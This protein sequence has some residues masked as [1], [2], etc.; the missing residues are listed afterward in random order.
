LHLALDDEDEL[1]AVVAVPRMR[2]GARQVVVAELL[3]QLET[4][5]PAQPRSKCGC[6]TPCEAR[7][8]P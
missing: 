2:A 7:L 3:D 1:D 4:D 8:I 6:A 5:L